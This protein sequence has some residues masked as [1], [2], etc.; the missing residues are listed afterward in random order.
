MN[1]KPIAPTARTDVETVSFRIDIATAE[2][3]KYACATDGVT[4]SEG[5]RQLVKIYL[6]GRTNNATIK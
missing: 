5:L 6:D 1:F 4:V 2:K 3:F